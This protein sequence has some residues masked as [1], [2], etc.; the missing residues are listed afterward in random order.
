MMLSG[1]QKK[2]LQ[3]FADSFPLSAHYKQGRRLRKGGWEV[4]FP[5]ITQDVEAKETF[6][7]AVDKL[8]SRGVL[9]A[10]WKRFREGNDLT[11]LY[12]EDPEKLYALLG[13]AHPDTARETLLA[14]LKARISRTALEAEMTGYCLHMLENRQSLQPI[15]ESDLIDILTLAS[16]TP[17]QA[18]SFPLRSLSVHLFRNSKRIEQ[19]I[20]DA[21][22]LCRRVCGEKLSRILDLNR[23]YPESTLTGQCVLHFHDGSSWNLNGKITVLPYATIKAITS[24]QWQTPEPRLLSI[25]NKETFYVAAAGLKDFAGFLY[26]SGRPNRAD[27]EIVKRLASSGAHLFHYGDL[28]PGGIIIFRSIYNLL[29]GK[30]LPWR[31]DVDTYN[32]WL[33]YGYPLERTALRTISSLEFPPLAPLI[34]RILETG[35]GVEQEVISPG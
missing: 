32:A 16:C 28:D 12:L 2:I 7:D 18:A 9:S 34:S 17:E 11:A 10:S 19:I 13:T 23:K 1:Y 30:L 15:N 8:C 14:A 31:M 5:E 35:K 26:T 21:D 3:V 20:Q 33:P 24:I 22:I 27:Q 6:L 4:R 25:E 29:D